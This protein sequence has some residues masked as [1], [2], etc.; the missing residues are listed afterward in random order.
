MLAI[1]HLSLA[2]VSQVGVTAESH[3][4]PRGSCALGAILH[5]VYDL[6]QF[7]LLKGVPPLVNSA[8]Q[9]FF[10]FRLNTYN[11]LDC[12]VRIVFIPPCRQMLAYSHR[13]MC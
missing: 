11:M 8:L 9:L 4:R 13:L 6:S 1:L 12:I 5:P 3:K 7:T 2:S 10:T